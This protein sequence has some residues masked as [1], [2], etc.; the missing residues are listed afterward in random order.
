MRVAAR[1]WRCATSEVRGEIDIVAW[2]G[3]ILVFC[4]VKARRDGAAGGPFAA[5]TARKQLQLRRLAAAF[6]A[7]S[8]LR[9]DHVRFDVVGV[10]WAQGGRAAVEHLRAV[11]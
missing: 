5:V 7:A 2:D 1:N 9:V 11:C 8:G 3:P 6:L 10:S 4:E